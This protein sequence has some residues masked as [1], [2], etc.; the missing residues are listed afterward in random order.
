MVVLTKGL[1]ANVRDGLLLGFHSSD[2]CPLTLDESELLRAPHLRLPSNHL[3]SVPHLQLWR[4]GDLRSNHWGP[5]TSRHVARTFSGKPDVMIDQYNLPE[6]ITPPC[7]LRRFTFFKD[8]NKLADATRS[9]S[10]AACMRCSVR[11]WRPKRAYLLSEQAPMKLRC[12]MRW[13]KA[14]LNCDLVAL[15]LR[16]GSHSPSSSTSGHG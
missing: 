4:F 15:T 8:R 12:R 10:M 1:R 14:V 16:F 5:S 13:R 11:C 9:G 3:R 6:H 2:Y 7:S